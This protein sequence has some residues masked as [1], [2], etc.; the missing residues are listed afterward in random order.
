MNKVNK[1]N[2]LNILIASITCC[3]MWLVT[4]NILEGM[5][6][7]TINQ[8]ISGAIGT[9]AFGLSLYITSGWKND[10]TED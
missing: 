9:G 8:T 1:D 10:D 4:S 5:V 3:I 2:M 7:T 6:C